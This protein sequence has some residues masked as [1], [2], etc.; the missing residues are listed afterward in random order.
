M[1]LGFNGMVRHD[2]HLSTMVNMSLDGQRRAS[3]AGRDLPGVR[4]ALS[5]TERPLGS[6]YYFERFAGR[7]CYLCQ[8]LENVLM[9]CY[10]F[11]TL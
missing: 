8:T 10:I 2:V 9:S 1:T 7:Q 6:F 4:L 3:A 11:G 5:L